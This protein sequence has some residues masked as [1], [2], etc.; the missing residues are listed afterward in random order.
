M[1]IPDNYCMV[2]GDFNSHSDNWGYE[3]TDR[4]GEEVEDWEIENNL[5]LVN[6]DTGY[7]IQYALLS[8]S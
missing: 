4:R 5:H 8:H 7:R 1:N 2:V 6:E 3:E